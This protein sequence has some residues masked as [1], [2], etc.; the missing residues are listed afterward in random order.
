METFL[1]TFPNGDSMRTILLLALSA[2]LC[3]VTA[4]EVLALGGLHPAGK[5]A[6]D[7]KKDWP[8]GLPDLINSA[9]RVCGY[10]VNANDFFYYRGDVASLNAF[11]AAY[12]KLPDIALT[13]V[14][15]TGSK[16]ET[17]ALGGDQ[18]TP[19]DWNVEIYRRGWG[20]PN[21]PRQTEKEPGYVVAV[22]VWLSDA[23]T[24]KNLE[25]PK[26]IDDVRSAGEIEEFIRKHR[27]GGLEK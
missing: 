24:L 10:W 18:K 19:Y 6:S 12:G 14:I 27:R 7:Y 15:H 2:T 9:D 20:T 13:V 22:H 11:L 8:G 21:D 23:I 3:G 5:I 1:S 26:H 25:I 4:T 17:G 16:P